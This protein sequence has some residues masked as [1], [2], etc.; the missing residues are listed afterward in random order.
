MPPSGSIFTRRGPIAPM[1]SQIEAE[2]GPPLNEN[3]SGRLGPALSK[4]ISNEE[5]VRFD[6]I[7]FAVA[8]RHQARG[9]SVF[10]HS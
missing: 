7:I 6:L 2:P 10:Q 5:N 8:D 1:C 9:S 4:R 3:I